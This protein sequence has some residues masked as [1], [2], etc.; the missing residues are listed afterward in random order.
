MRSGINNYSKFQN[1]PTQMIKDKE[2]MART[3]AGIS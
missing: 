1:Q 3:G 2:V